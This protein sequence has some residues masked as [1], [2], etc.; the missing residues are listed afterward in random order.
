M[1]NLDNRKEV[2]C[3]C[4]CERKVPLLVGSIEAEL[5]SP[6]FRVYL[7]DDG[8]GPNMWMML[9][10]GSWHDYECDCA[11][12]IHSVLGEDGI[13]S[14]LEE[15]SDSPWKKID[16]PELH[17]LSRDEVINQEGGKEWVFETFNYFL[18]NQAEVHEFLI[19]E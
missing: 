1:I 6:S 17:F 8:T 2:N 16:I 13:T 7:M 12:I 19:R 3:P 9:H 18:D 5:M 10:T 4:G 11:I 14:Y 15:Q